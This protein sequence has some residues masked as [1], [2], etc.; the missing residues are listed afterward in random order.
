MSND[1]IPPEFSR[2]GIRLPWALIGKAL[3]LAS[4]VVLFLVVAYMSTIFAKT[5]DIASLQALPA[6]VEKLEEFKVEQKMQQSSTNA[7]IGAM[8]Q[9]LAALKAQINALKEDSTKNTDR[10]LQRLGEM[11]RKH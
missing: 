1:D 9:D 2:T 6:R 4:P 3:I 8:Q 7:S 10:I 11:D 5:E